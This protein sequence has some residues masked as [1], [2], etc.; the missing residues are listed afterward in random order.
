MQKISLGLLMI[1]LLGNCVKEQPKNAITIFHAGS[2]S[3]PLKAAADSFKKYNPDITIYLEAAGSVECARKITELNRSCDLFFSADYHV[4]KLLLATNHTGFYIP[5]AGNRMVLAYSPKSKGAKAINPANWPDILLQSDVAYGRSDPNADPCGYRTVLTLKLAEQYLK[6]PGLADSILS[7]N[8]QFIRPK[9]VDLITLLQTGAIDYFLI[10]ESVAKQHN[11]SYLILPDSINLSNPVLA[12]HYESVSTQ[13]RGTIPNKF[14]TINGE[15]IVY[16]LTIPHSS[17]NP[18][19]A[20]KFTQYFLSDSGGIK[21]LKS[22][23]QNPLIPFDTLGCG[24]IPDSLLKFSVQNEN[25][26]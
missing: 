5:F 19:L 16:A 7:K 12:K 8:N 17:K 4:I 1:A 22:M 2:L 14:I 21:I 20:L 23:G 6:H 11:L 26:Q 3:L 15:P 25:R 24:K 9:E 13:I 10:Y 18:E